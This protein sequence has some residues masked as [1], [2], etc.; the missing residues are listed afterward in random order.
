[1]TDDVANQ[2]PISSRGDRKAT[3]SLIDHYFHRDVAILLFSFGIGFAF[4]DIKTILRN[5]FNFKVV[6]VSFCPYL[7]HQT[8]PVDIFGS[9]IHFK[10]LTSS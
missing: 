4:S 1:M 5:N 7:D 6:P 3:E 9:G 10:V 8:H 2:R